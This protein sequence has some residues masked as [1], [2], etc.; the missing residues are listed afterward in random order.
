MRTQRGYQLFKL[1][2]RSEPQLRPFDEVRRDIENAIRSERIEPET[3]KLLT[4]LRS[5]AVIEWKDETLRQ[6][7][8]KRVAETV[9]Q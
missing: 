2:S 9:N 8:E 3:Q 7:Y 6:L 1:E 4:R 5:Q